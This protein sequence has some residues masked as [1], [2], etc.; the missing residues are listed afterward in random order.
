ML[1]THSLVNPHRTKRFES[2]RFISKLRRLGKTGRRQ[3][4]ALRILDIRMAKHVVVVPSD[5]ALSRPS[6][7]TEPLWDLCWW[8]FE[9]S[10]PSTKKVSGKRNRRDR[11][12]AQTRPPTHCFLKSYCPYTVH[13]YSARHRLARP[14]ETRKNDSIITIIAFVYA[15]KLLSCGFGS[16]TGNRTRVFRSRI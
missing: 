8:P 7:A 3:P 5:R 6:S 15:E 1:Y 4:S 10:S 9:V 14:Q 11:G 12:S 16:A 2:M 13:C